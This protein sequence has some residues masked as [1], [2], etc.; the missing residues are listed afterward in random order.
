MRRGDLSWVD[1]EPVRGTEAH[2]TRPAVIVSRTGD[3]V[4]WSSVQSPFL[5][6][7]SG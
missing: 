1:F 7:G 3:G 2:G 5:P 6:W 4:G